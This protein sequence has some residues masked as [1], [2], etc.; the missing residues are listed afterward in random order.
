MKI[1][2]GKL[3]RFVTGSK[4]DRQRIAKT[5]AEEEVRRMAERRRAKRERKNAEEGKP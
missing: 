3:L 4:A 5:V 2:L 1:N